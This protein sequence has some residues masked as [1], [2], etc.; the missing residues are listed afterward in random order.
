MEEHGYRNG[1]HHDARAERIKGSG[2][3]PV[4]GDPA[5]S[6]HG[7]DAAKVADH[8]IGGQQA[9]AILGRGYSVDH[10]H[11]GQ[12]THAVADGGQHDTQPEQQ[13]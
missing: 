2:H 4:I 6:H 13:G 9:R 5:D 10:A 1:N 7:D 8:Q 11:A 12:H 3:A